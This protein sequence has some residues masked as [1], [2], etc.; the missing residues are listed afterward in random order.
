MENIF[1]LMLKHVYQVIFD[2]RA[3]HLRKLSLPSQRIHWLTVSQVQRNL[4]QFLRLEAETRGHVSE[5]RRTRGDAGNIS[6][7]RTF[8]R[9]YRGV[10]VLMMTLAELVTRLVTVDCRL[11]TSLLTCHLEVGQHQSHLQRHSLM[12]VSIPTY[13]FKACC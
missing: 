9:S 2:T 7:G 11:V 6:L 13:Y 8:S 1:I 12:F 4:E 5:L 3:Y 10:T